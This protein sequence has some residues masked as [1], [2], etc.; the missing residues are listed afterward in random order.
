[1]EC[2]ARKDNEK[3]DIL[4]LEHQILLGYIF[5]IASEIEHL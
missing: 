3:C 4:L 2:E 5:C 1:M